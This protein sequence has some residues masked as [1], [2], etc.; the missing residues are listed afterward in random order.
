[1]EALISY[2]QGHLPFE[3]CANDR[4]VHAGVTESNWP[5]FMKEVYRVLKPG[6]GWAQ[7][8]EFGYPYCISENNSLPQDAPLSKVTQRNAT[9]FNG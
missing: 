4:I 3:V 7:C 9:A 5:P 2:S 6:L 8:I 1:M